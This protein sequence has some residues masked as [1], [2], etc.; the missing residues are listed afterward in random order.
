MVKPKRK[1]STDRPAGQLED[2]TL[3][4]TGTVNYGGRPRT[5]PLQPGRKVQIGARVTLELRARLEQLA[6]QNGHSL[7]QEIER[8]LERGLDHD[9]LG[10][11]LDAL[12]THI[13]KLS[14]RKGTP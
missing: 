1:Q 3:V 2:T 10:R 13:A 5:K 14:A 7:A 6:L 9:A 12:S 8:L 11:R 4:A